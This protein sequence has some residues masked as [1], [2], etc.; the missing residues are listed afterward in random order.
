KPLP[1][2]RFHP[3]HGTAAIAATTPKRSRGR[4]WVRVLLLLP[5]LF[6]VVTVAQVAVLR[7]VDP[8]TS[9]FMLARQAQAWGQ[10]DWT[11]R[12]AYDWRD[13]DAIAAS[14]PMSVIAAEDARLARRLGCG[15]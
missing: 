14:L 10:G 6:V 15:P 4:R 5:V 11:Y 1:S 13:L 8:P 12:V 3:M 2:P 9:A 7:F